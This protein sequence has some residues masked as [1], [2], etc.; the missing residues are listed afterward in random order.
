MPWLSTHPARRHSYVR[1]SKPAIL[2][3]QV[4][5]NITVLNV[6]G[7]NPQ[8]YYNF[9]VANV[10]GPP[11]LGI[12]KS[13]AGNFAPGENGAQY[14][15]LVTDTGTGSSSG[16]VTVTETVPSGETLV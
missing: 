5:T 12:T 11:V 8:A 3:L 15:V 10:A 9:P 13:H 7:C 4:T 16:M 1:L 2:Q 14:T 6:G